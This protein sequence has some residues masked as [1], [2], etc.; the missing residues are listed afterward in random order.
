MTCDKSVIGLAHLSLT[1]SVVARFL[2]ADELSMLLIY[3]YTQN[4][5]FQ[6][7]LLTIY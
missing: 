7:E 6:N 2:F 5:L 4:T 3:V 1:V